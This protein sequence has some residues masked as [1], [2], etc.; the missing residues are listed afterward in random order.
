MTRFPCDPHH[1]KNFPNHFKYN[2]VLV[3]EAEV[4][5]MVSKC[6]NPKCKAPFLYLHEG[7][8]VPVRLAESRIELFWL[9][10]D[11]APRL[12]VEV[13]VDGIMNVVPRG[14]IRKAS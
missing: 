13:A 5:A 11:C 10:A 12:S 9:C 2:S 8:L 1:I 6:A 7:R 4:N 3:P 14:T